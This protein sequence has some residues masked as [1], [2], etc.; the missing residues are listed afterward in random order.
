M[1]KN[2]I[3]QLLALALPVV[4]LYLG[5]NVGQASAQSNAPWTQCTDGRV[6]V[7]CET[8][9]C[10]NGDT[11]SDGTCNL[12]DTGARLTD[13]RNDS[14]CANPLSGCGE[15]RYFPSGASASCSVRVEEND[16]NCNLYAVANP[17][18]T[19][20]PTVSP[21]SSPSVGGSTVSRCVSLKATPFEGNA[22]LTVVFE[23]MATDPNGSIR[24]YEFVFSN[25]DGEVGTVEQKT[26]KVSQKFDEPGEYLAK[27]TAVDSQ[28]R[29]VTSS[30]CETTVTV[31]SGTKGGLTDE[32]TL[33]ETGS[34]LWIGLAIVAI[35]ALGAYMYERY[36]LA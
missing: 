3:Y 12:S 25:E 2:K 29:R 15:V 16:N 34:E 31:R 17:T 23:G 22:P 24:E 6:I 32:D 26:N 13:A 8:Y 33:P 9:D 5:L 35:G 21:T 4:F 11:N 30:A 14:F 1:I 27:L 20:Q 18:F 36:R 19:P 28:G 10:P 7:R